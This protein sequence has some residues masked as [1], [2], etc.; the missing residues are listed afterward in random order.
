M[1]LSIHDSSVDSRSPSLY[2]QCPRPGTDDTIRYFFSCHAYQIL[3]R[4]PM[5]NIHLRS[6]CIIELLQ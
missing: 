2:V 3:F 5:K 1:P 4:N 6:E